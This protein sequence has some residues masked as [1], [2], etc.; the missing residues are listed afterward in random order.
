MKS[1]QGV[2]REGPRATLCRMG[3]KFLSTFGLRGRADEP[4][5]MLSALSVAGGLSRA[6]RGHRCLRALE[7]EGRQSFA[8]WADLGEQCI[9]CA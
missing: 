2:H 1:R 9:S 7:G 6:A 3:S 4:H 5:A 8:A